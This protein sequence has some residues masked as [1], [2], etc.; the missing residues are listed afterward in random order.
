MTKTIT[1]I[2]GTYQPEKCGVAHYTS[3]LRDALK[4]QGIKSICSYNSC[5]SER[6]K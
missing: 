1:L 2:A 6:G 5:S 3:R 4:Q